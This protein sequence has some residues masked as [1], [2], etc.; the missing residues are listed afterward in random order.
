MAHDVFIS[1]SSKDKVTGDAVCAALE[2]HGISCWIA[3]RDIEPGAEWAESIIDAITDARCLVLVF[4]GHANTS[5]QIRREVERAVNKD[6]PIIPLRI[7]DVPPSKTLEYFISTPHWLD[8]FTPPLDR[9]LER[10]AQAIRRRLGQTPAD[11]AVAGKPAAA[12]TATRASVK[13]ATPEAD[14][15]AVIPAGHFSMGSN[16]A[17][18]TR[19][20]V[21]DQWGAWERPQHKVTLRSFLLAKHTVTR[22]EFAEFAAVTGYSPS[23]SYVWTGSKYEFSATANWQSPGFEQTDRHPVVCVSHDDAEAYIRWYSQKMG[24]AYRLPSE[25]EWEY[26][27]RAGT[28]TARYW[29]DSST[30]QCDYANGADL[31]A[32]DKFPGWTV[33]ECRDG[34]VYTAPVGSFRPNAWGLYDMLGNVWEWTA[35]CW[36]ESYAGAPSDGSAW[37][38]G[39]CGGRVVRGGAWSGIPWLLRSALRSWVASGNRYVDSGFRL[40]RTLP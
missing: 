25:A 14:D 12:K 13:T 3:P 33:A 20:K 9:H 11:A 36:N 29:G 40:A 1:V 32:K 37:T 38:T 17:E 2:V 31:T 18:T 22:G 27:A 19:E 15:M 30:A 34:W 16:A 4:S 23:G 10:L 6:I 8:A 21:P 7:E 28:T 39:N 5:P 24:R 35:D 26:A